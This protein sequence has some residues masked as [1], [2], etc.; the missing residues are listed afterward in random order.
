MTLPAA[1]L[2]PQPLVDAHVHLFPDRLFDAIWRQ[3]V[4]DYGWSVLHR[5]YW[6]ESLA[7]LKERGVGPIVYS[8]YAHRPGIAKGLND[9]NLAVLEETPDLYCYAAFHP[10]DADA[11]AMAASVLEHPRILGFKLQ[12]LV[13]RFS[14]HDERLFPLYELVMAKGK[15]L[16]LH[17]GTG[18][19]GNE[20]V[21][22]VHFRKLLAR[23]PDLPATVAHMGALEYGAFG[24]LLSDHPGIFLDTAFAFLP[25]LGFI[26][27]LEA[28]F[29]EKHR[30]RI[31]YGSDF[32]NILF[33]R[34]EEIDALLGLG[35]SQAFYDAVFRDNGLLLIGQA[36]QIRP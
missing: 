16:L 3:F 4:A 22:I 5:L 34:E 20:F 11:L 15:R 33:P 19:V 36:G 29:L 14:P 31:L 32:P 8:N 2:L 24:E 1:K 35:L 21:G 6:R 30:E 12:L 18:P 9:W 28:D 25:G 7:Y 13:Q 26:C 10:G 27:D 17:T 23:Y